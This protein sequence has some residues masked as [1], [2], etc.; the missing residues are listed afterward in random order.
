MPGIQISKE[1]FPRENKHKDLK[2]MGVRA[3]VIAKTLDLILNDTGQMQDT[4]G[5]AVF[6]IVQ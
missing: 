1:N 4:Q 5:T 6:Q 2:V 3:A